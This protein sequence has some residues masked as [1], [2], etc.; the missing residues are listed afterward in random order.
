MLTHLSIQ[1]IVLIDHLEIGFEKGFSVLTG[2]TG[3]GK[4]IVLDALGLVTGMRGD[5]GLIRTHQEQATVS[6]IFDIE[7]CQVD[8][9]LRF[10][11]DEQAIDL[12]QNELIL[13]RI[14]QRNGKTRCFIN[15]QTVSLTFL[16]NIGDYLFE[17]HGQFDQ[18]FSATRQ[19]TLLDQFS[20]H[21][22]KDFTPAY[23]N[24]K[25]AF[26]IYQEAHQAH[27]QWLKNRDQDLQNQIFLDQLITDFENVRLQEDEEEQLLIKR[28]NLSESGRSSTY[29]SQA[30][31]I[32]ESPAHVSTAIFSAH[33]A[34]ERGGFESQ[35]FLDLLDALNRAGI[36]VQEACQSMHEIL[37]HQKDAVFEL[38]RIDERLAEIRALT[39]KYQQSAS[40][41]SILY[42]RAK[43]TRLSPEDMEAQ[44]RSYNQKVETAKKHYQICAQNL[45]QLRLKGA[46]ILQKA[47]QKEL[48]E[49]KLTDA[50]FEI[51]CTQHLEITREG[52]DS[53]VFQASMNPGQLFTPIQKSA[54]GGELARFMLALKVVL[55][56]QENLKTIIFDEIDR[57]VSGA[58]AHA[59]GTRL[60]RLGQQSQVLCITHSAQVAACANHHYVVSKTTSENQT[61]TQLVHI[62]EAMRIQELA[63][64]I[65]GDTI[66]SEAQSAAQKLR[67]THFKA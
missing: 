54:S 8:H 15:D 62:D 27:S 36:E 24:L 49:L 29:I 51:T 46:D 20:A 56:R 17:I 2:E 39:R 41:L 10:L 28:Q 32:L 38:E 14:L 37:E 23:Q 43:Q 4:S 66:T 48:P 35:N 7:G 6:A 3:A 11:C 65:S 1:N 9:P 64:L 53:I 31:K 12:S 21:H 55:A 42:T 59:I 58:V 67:E 61:Q 45:S 40:E 25:E 47:I 18:L 30:L 33:K 5:S 52:Q 22:E 13:R 19:R 26:E 50:R 34:L 16:K 63:R 60:D 44:E 57:G